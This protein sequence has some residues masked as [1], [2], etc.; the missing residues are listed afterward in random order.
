MGVVYAAHDE[1]LGRSVALKLIR[2]DRSDEEARKRFWREA[3][4]AAR[5]NHPGVCQI[6]EIGEEEGALFI[7]MELLE[8]KS[9][10]Q[11]LAPGPLPTPEAI[12]IALGVLG[13]LEDLHRH[14]L[15]HRDLKPSNVFLTSH[16]VK[17]LDFGL[18]RALPSQ[19]ADEREETQSQLTLPGAVAGTPRY[20]SP[21]QFKGLPVDAR[22]DLFAVAAMLFEMLTGRHAFAG[23]TM[24]EIFHATLY[25][26]PPALVGSEAAAAVDRVIRRGLAK[27][28]EDRSA[29]ASVMARELREAFLAEGVGAATRAVVMTRLMVLPFRTLRPDADTDF[30]AFS[31]PDA[32]TSS[33]SGLDA[34]V[35]RSSLAAARYAG[36]APDLERIAAEAN[37]DVV[38]TGTIL[39][40]GERLRVSTQLVEAPA[41]TL[42]WSQTSQVTLRDIFQLQDDLALRIVESL[43]LPLTARE[44]RQ[45]RHDVPASPTAYE[46]Y[47]RANQLIDQVGLS[48]HEPF[49]LARDLYLRCLED[50]ARYAPAWARL[51]RCYRLMGKAGEEPEENLARAELALKRAVELNPSLVVAHKLYAQLETDLGHAADGMTRLLRRSQSARADP[52]LFAG[53]VQA[54]RYCGLLE[55]SVAADQQARRLDPK[56]DTG[57]RHTYWLLGEFE[58]AL[59]EVAPGRLYFEALVLTSMGREAEALSVLRETENEKRPAL[60]RAFVASLRA[61]LEGKGEESLEA[62][63]TCLAQFRDPE[64]QYYLARQLAY[65]GARERAIG[66]IGRAV[67]QG[68]YCPQAL[69]RDPWLTSLRSTPAFDAIL[70]RAEAGRR[71]AAAA[72]TEVGGEGLLGVRLA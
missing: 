56:I 8:G 38:V 25:E 9:L 23:R 11:R 5:V 50:D 65:L 46:F 10:A 15:V 43:S 31:L 16:G 20:M 34:L 57:V 64:A 55:A 3:R 67:E 63:E 60:M 32:I 54:C 42:L 35:V 49:A 44:H 19:T 61:L 72:F 1:R 48:A 41:G 70:G 24:M 40:A 22:S 62:T 53:L 21:E 71:A 6:H 17:L 12:Q 59:Q 18:A 69:A 39:R 30:L 36:E 29:T 28:P 27:R 7:A 2:E 51:G 37:V 52:E 4:A 33:L 68:F 14:G 13:A 66:E 47:L 58:R 45:L 26:E